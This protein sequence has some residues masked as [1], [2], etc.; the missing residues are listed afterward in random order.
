MHLCARPPHGIF[1]YI[2]S[3]TMKI[4]KA[5]S[6]C[7][8]LPIVDQA[9][10]V[11]VACSG[12]SSD[13]AQVGKLHRCAIIAACRLMHGLGTC[14]RGAQPTSAFMCHPDEPPLR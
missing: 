3:S 14:P 7:K 8:P 9:L 4:A 6:A 1:R 13:A 10:G 11:T 12:H 5:T 2:N